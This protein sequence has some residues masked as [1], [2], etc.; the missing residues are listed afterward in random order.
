MFMQ[1]SQLS[2][3]ERFE[4]ADYISGKLTHRGLIAQPAEYI[5]KLVAG[6]I[7]DYTQEADETPDPEDSGRAD[8]FADHYFTRS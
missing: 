7:E 4:L 8:D 6:W 3:S 5:A 2:K 1:L